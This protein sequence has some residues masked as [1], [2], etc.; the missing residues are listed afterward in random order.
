M[1]EGSQ[2]DVNDQPR[3]S[4]TSGND[5]AEIVVVGSANLD[6]VVPVPR[7]PRVGETILGGDH[8]LVAGGKGANQ[9]VAAARLGRRTCFIGRIGDDAA[10]VRLRRSLVEAGVDVEHLHTTE[11]T[12]SG[13]ALITVT[14]DGD[15]SIVVSPGAND[16]LS[17]VDIE[18]AQ[19][20]L[21]SAAVL[22]VQHEVPADVVHAAVL[23]AWG[24]VILN[25]APARPL[26]PDVLEAVDV[27]VPNQTELAELAGG[28]VPTTPQD[29][30]GLV[31]KLG[32]ETVVVT[33]GARGAL[34]ID[35]DSTELVPAPSI[36]PIDTTGAGDAFCGALA[37][38][39]AQ[40][41]DLLAATQWAVRVGAVTCLRVGAQTSL[42]T[43]AEVQDLIA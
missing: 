26:P 10:G 36:I 8:S 3:G 18:P 39:L 14:P 37:D 6:T 19:N 31:R 21:E 42:P 5:A 27:L 1:V 20:L 13:I 7:Q 4:S 23:A 33:L 30:V 29:A 11:A 9:A 15:N 41:E 24:Q 2:H 22:L 34:V 12:P 16:R 40:G 17:S 25:P 35:G 43:A 38:G 32:Q 28:P